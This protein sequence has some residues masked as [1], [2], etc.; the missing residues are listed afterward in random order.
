[1]APTSVSAL[2]STTFRPQELGIRAYALSHKP[3]KEKSNNAQMQL[4]VDPFRV[5]TL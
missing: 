4:I 1:M 5:F 2:T 3:L